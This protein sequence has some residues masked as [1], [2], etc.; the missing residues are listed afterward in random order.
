[1]TSPT[2]WQIPPS[3]LRWLP[4]VPARAAV[5]VLLRHSVRDPLPPGDAGNMLPITGAGV[6]LARELGV[7]L[8]SR[9]RAVHTSPVLRC[10]Q[11][12]EALCE[13]ASVR[14]PIRRDRLLG[15]PGVYVVDARRAWRNWQEKGHEGVMAHLV[16]EDEPLPG[17]AA[18]D[19]AA[20]I[21]VQHMLAAAGVEPGFHLFVSHDSVVIATAARILGEPFA[22]DAWPWYLEGAFFWQQE[23]ALVVA[24]RDIRRTC[25]ADGD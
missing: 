12:A 25:R 20:R 10:V 4:E 24:Y 1:M 13:G 6:R 9:L 11:T 21:L 23:G 5:A 17:M 7:L 2:D 19:A 8:G 22:A 16:A 3:V 15:D 14:V 18:P